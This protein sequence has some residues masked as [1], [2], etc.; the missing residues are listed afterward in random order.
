MIPEVAMW[1]TIDTM[2]FGAS[3]SVIRISYN[4]KATKA[5][6]I[7]ADHNQNNCKSSPPVAQF[8]VYRHFQI[9]FNINFSMQEVESGFSQ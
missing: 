4:K 1:I 7:I 9:N 3:E 8:V 6:M 2:Y 5:H